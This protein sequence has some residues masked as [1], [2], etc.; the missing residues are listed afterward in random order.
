MKKLVIFLVLLLSS[1]QLVFAS[2]LL[3]EADKQEVNVDKNTGNLSGNVRITLDDL[4]VFGQK[5]KI[6]LDPETK[7]MKDASFVN[8]AYAIQIR[9]NKKNELKA[10]ILS[11]SLLKKTVTATGD[12]QTTVFEEGSPTVIIT[13]DTQEYNTQTKVMK[14]KGSVIVNYKDVQTFS[15]EG[16]AYLDG[17]NELKDLFLVGNAKLKQGKN[18]IEGDK[19]EYK[20]A[21]KVAI[22]TGKMTHSDITDDEKGDRI[23]VWA[24]HQQ[25]DKLQNILLINK[26]AVIKYKDITAR[27]PKAT[28]LPDKKTNKL[29][30]IIF[31]G[32]ANIEQNDRNIEADRIIL[33]MKPKNFFAEGRVKTT[34]KNVQSNQNATF[35]GKK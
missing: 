16:I 33:T 31:I 18:L 21:T 24:G 19:F 8:N 7:Q 2:N 26:N 28:V 30:E 29:N 6:T 32:R 4:Q 17:N 20:P 25:Y 34:I 1:M 22:V 11:L 15:N 12:S 13:A 27:G 10:N 14:A 5:V 9:G 3:I 23:Q 35:G